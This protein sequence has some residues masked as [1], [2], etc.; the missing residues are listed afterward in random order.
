MQ[1]INK[2]KTPFFPATLIVSL[3]ISGALMAPVSANADN[4]NQSH[5]QSERSHKFKTE[6]KRNY[7]HQAA[8]QSSYSQSHSNRYNRPHSYRYTRSNSYGYTRPH[9]QIVTFTRPTPHDYDTIT[10]YT[11]HQLKLIFGL[12]TNNTNIIYQRY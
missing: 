2:P 6:K 4:R 10:T 11:P 1:A 7:R 9:R 5:N 12:Q 3:L 8:R